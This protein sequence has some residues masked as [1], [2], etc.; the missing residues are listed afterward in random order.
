MDDLISRTIYHPAIAHPVIC[1]TE[2][3]SRVDW[4]IGGAL[5]VLA[6]AVSIQLLRSLQGSFKG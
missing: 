4:S 3:M 6:G 1:L 2:I 5:V